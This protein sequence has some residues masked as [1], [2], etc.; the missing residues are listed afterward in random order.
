MKYYKLPNSFDPARELLINPSQI[1]AV[2]D[3][4]PTECILKTTSSDF[5]IKMSKEDV[6]KKL[7]IQVVL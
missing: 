6:L 7:E 4:G 3:K 5:H 1:I 2:E